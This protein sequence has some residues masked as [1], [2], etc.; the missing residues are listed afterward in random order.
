MT[1]VQ[2]CALP[3]YQG[4]FDAVNKIKWSEDKKTLRIIFL[5]GD[6][7]PHMDYKDDVKYPVTCEKAVRKNIIINT[8]Q[9]GDDAD[10]TRHWKEI[11]KRAEGSYAQIAQSGGATP[12]QL[13]VHLEQP[14][15]QQRP[16]I[17]VE[18]VSIYKQP[19]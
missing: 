1:G 8:V 16:P 13:Q 5:V 15:D 11:C 2:T 3:I 14:G 10:C 12:E 9:C 19:V 4:L 18:R 17:T 6:A 7:P